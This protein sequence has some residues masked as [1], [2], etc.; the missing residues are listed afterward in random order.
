[1]KNEFT[2]QK[3]PCT[4][5]NVGGNRMGE[6]KLSSMYFYSDWTEEKTHNIKLADIIGFTLHWR[7]DGWHVEVVTKEK[8]GEY[9]HYSYELSHF[10]YPKQIAEMIADDRIKILNIKN[11]H[12]SDNFFEALE[13][14]MA[15]AKT[16]RAEYLTRQISN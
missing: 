9:D 14:V 3:E 16:L 10:I 1:M 6:I 12:N 8:K 5:Q 11:Y 7:G 15:W 2:K 13:K 4:I